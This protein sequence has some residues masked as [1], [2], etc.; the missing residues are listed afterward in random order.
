MDKAKMKEVEKR[1]R[2]E[3]QRI[4]AELGETVNGLHQPNTEELPDFSDLSS[5]ET[6]RNFLLRLKERERNLLIKIEQTLEK[7]RQGTF[8]VCDECGLEI[9]E[10]RIEARPVVSL[11]IECKTK[12]EERERRG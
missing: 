9:G 12:Q 1:L 8:G 6:N 5:L 2:K 10:K 3:R 7:I 11:C 4:L